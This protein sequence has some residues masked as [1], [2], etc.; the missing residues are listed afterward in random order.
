MTVYVLCFLVSVFLLY[1]AESQKFLG[2]ASR[3]SVIIA[4]LIPCMIAGLRHETIG[5]DVT[6]YTKELFLVAQ[7]TGSFFEYLSSGYSL[8]SWDYTAVKDIEFGFVVLCYLSSK[9][10][11]SMQFLLFFI[12]A[13][14][15]IPIYKGLRVFGKTQPVWLGMTVYY[16][17]FFNQTLNLMRQ[18]IAMAFLF[19]AF[20]FLLSNSYR[21]YFSIVVIAS[22]FHLSAAIGVAIFAIYQLVAKENMHNKSLKVLLLIII[23]VVVILGLPLVARVMEY[24]GLRYADYISGNLELMP[25]QF[26]YRIPILLI[27]MLR[28][29]Y[30]RKNN[31]LTGLFLVVIAYDLL[32][33]QLTSIFSQSGRIALYFGEYYMLIYPAVCMASDSK[34]NRRIMRIFVMCYLCVYWWYTYVYGGSGETVPYISIWG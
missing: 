13:L 2:R 15:V 5:T 7:E 22:L 25:N 21:R 27:L 14:T 19:Y 34:N 3:I 10:L 26:L 18:W 16:L 31:C 17:L 8:Y 6:G 4:I 32:A 30:L 11:N 29:R 9:V 23:G 24:L 1:Y 33:S 28:W 20:Q 12:Q